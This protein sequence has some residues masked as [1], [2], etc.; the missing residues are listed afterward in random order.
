MGCG[1]WVMVRGG[2]DVPCSPPKAHMAPPGAFS[3]VSHC[4]KPINELE[5]IYLFVYLNEKAQSK[6]Q[7]RVRERNMEQFH[8]RGKGAAGRREGQGVCGGVSLREKILNGE[9]FRW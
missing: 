2:A 1:S 5:F 6:E 9:T 7:D 8:P 4:Q 3:P